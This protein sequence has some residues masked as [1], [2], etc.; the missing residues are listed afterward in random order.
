MVTA[1]VKPETGFYF[2]IQC[3]Y[4]S[5]LEIAIDCLSPCTKS[6]GTYLVER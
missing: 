1:G 5:Y 4:H 2:C 6:I 3:G